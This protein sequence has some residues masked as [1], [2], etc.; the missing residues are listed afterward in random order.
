M[1]SCPGYCQVHVNAVMVDA[2]WVMILWVAKNVPGTGELSCVKFNSHHMTLVKQTDRRLDRCMEGR[3]MNCSWW[4]GQCVAC[5]FN[6]ISPIFLLQSTCHVPL[7]WQKRGYKTTIGKLWRTGIL[8]DYLVPE[9]LPRLNW[10][11]TFII[12]YYNHATNQWCRKQGY[13]GAGAQIP[14][15]PGSYAP[16][17]NYPTCFLIW[18]SFL[19]CLSHFCTSFRKGLQCSLIQA[20]PWKS[21]WVIFNKENMYIYILYFWVKYRYIKWSN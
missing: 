20:Q 5:W 18:N 21:W 1:S 16:A 14:P 13:V 10:W 8:D 15:P 3:K 11:R 6:Y 2:N 7:Q 4:D 19:P 12:S 17:T 9:T